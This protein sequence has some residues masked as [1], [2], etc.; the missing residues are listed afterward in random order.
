MVSSIPEMD[1]RQGIEPDQSSPQAAALAAA[2]RQFAEQMPDLV[3]T[4][5]RDAPGGSPCP[6]RGVG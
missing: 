5:H 4:E 1:N 3:A 6:S 2:Q